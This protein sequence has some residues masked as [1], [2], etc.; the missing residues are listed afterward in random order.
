MNLARSSAF[1]LTLLLPASASAGQG[2]YFIVPPL[3][4]YPTATESGRIDSSA[5]LPRWGQSEPLIPLRSVSAERRAKE[6]EGW[7]ALREVQQ[8]DKSDMLV[9]LRI[10]TSSAMVSGRCVASDDPRL[11]Q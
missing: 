3:D 10:V 4:Q 7:A 1:V 11:R 9:K 6:A 2:W 8:Q 5:A